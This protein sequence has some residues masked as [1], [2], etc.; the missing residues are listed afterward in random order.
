MKKLETSR[1]ILLM[2]LSF[3]GDSGGILRVLLVL[4]L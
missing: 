1:R 2:I 3:H 4:V